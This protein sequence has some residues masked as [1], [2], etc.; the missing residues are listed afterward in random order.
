MVADTLSCAPVMDGPTLSPVLDVLNIT[1][2]SSIAA[3]KGLDFD[4]ITSEQQDDV[5]TRAIRNDPT[6]GLRLVDVPRGDLT[7]L[8]DK[9]T[10]KLRPFIPATCRQRVYEVVHGLAHPGVKAMKKLV[11]DKFVW[12]KMG[13]EVTRWARACAHCQALKIHRHI[14]APLVT[15]PPVQRRFEHIHVDVIGPLPPSLGYTHL[16]TIVDRFTRWPEAF[17]VSETSTLTIAR[18]LLQGWIARFGTSAIITSDRG[19]QFVSELWKQFATSL[20]V[21]LRPTTSYHPQANG[22][23]ER[24]HRDLKASLRARLDSAGDKWTDQLPW[25]LLGLRTTFKEDLHASSAELVF[26]EALSVPGDFVG[27]STDTSDPSLLLGRLREEVQQMRPVPTSRHGLE[28]THVP[29][30]IRGVEY[31]FVRRDG[32]KGPLQRPYAGPYRVIE[33]SE[34]TFKLE[35]GGRTDTVTINRLK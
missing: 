11:T 13:V 25:V 31:V 22:L 29:D 8:C 34:K 21:E 27:S 30:D 12:P 35:V 28:P 1:S 32:H 24:L 3:I 26:G 23:V 18:T 10:G 20:G 2:M 9:S 19:S 7:L 15:F 17:P 6:T 14:K 33:H 16:L 5:G 4:E